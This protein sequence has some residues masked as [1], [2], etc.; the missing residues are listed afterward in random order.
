MKAEKEI[1]KVLKLAGIKDI[2]TKTHGQARNKINVIEAL[3]KAL[4]KLN[5]TKIQDRHIAQL[6]IKTGA[7]ERLEKISEN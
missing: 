1:A 6:G 4:L 2:W 7:L 3:K 5:E